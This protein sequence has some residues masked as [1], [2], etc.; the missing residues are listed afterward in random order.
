M[1]RSILLILLFATTATAQDVPDGTLVLSYKNGLIGRIARRI[2]KD[3]YTHIAIVVDGKVHESDW[4]RS[5]A[6]PVSR[7][8]KRR[9]VNEYYVPNTPYDNA[10]IARLRRSVPIGEPYRLAGYFAPHKA[11]GD[12][13]CSVYVARALN[14]TGRFQIS[15]WTG[16]E[17]QRIINQL[18]NQYTYS[19]TVRR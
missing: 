10:Q 4:P 7:Y 1:I 8:G 14:A 19:H 15:R 17:P 6:T 18:N 13:W 2:T 5:K 3:H 12:V 16:R 11:S 9:T